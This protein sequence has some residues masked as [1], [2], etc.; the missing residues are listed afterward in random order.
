MK[1]KIEPIKVE[2][3][4]LGDTIKKLLDTTG[5]AVVFEKITQAV[6]IEDCGCKRRQEKLNK[7]FPYESNTDN[8]KT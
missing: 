3:R 2:P 4:G 8:Q 6:G 7:M 1:Y 5:V